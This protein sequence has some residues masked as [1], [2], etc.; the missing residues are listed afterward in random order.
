MTCNTSAVDRE[1]AEQ[2]IFPAQG[3]DEGGA[4]AAEIDDGAAQRCA[5][6]VGL[7]VP[8]INGMDQLFAGQNARVRLPRSGP[9]WS[10]REIFGECRR[11]PALSSRMEPVPVVDHQEAE[12]GLAQPHRLFEHRVEHRREVAG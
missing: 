2:K 8:E 9:I 10:G 6:P 11:H 4:R 12:C 1:S 7:L 3:D 5:H